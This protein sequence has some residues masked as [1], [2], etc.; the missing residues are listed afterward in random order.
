MEASSSTLRTTVLVIVSAIV[1]GSIGI[2]AYYAYG[3]WLGGQNSVIAPQVAIPSMSS[4]DQVL[5]KLLKSVAAVSY[6]EDDG[7]KKFSDSR[8]GLEFSY[9]SDWTYTDEGNN[10]TLLLFHGANKYRTPI[11]IAVLKADVD[12]E[13]ASDKLK[14]EQRQ[15]IEASK[16]PMG[17]VSVDDIFET[18][19]QKH[20]VLIHEYSGEGTH[21]LVID[22]PERRI[23]ITLDLYASPEDLSG[24]AFVLSTLKLNEVR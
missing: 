19:F 4:D 8:V 16:R 11:S 22:W 17:G 3:S 10:G 14:E 7:G 15:M 20:P 9:P 21:D 23:Q 5:L 18:V 12:I 1:G 24:M 2:G 6:D 13:A